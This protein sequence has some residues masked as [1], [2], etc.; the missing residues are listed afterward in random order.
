MSSDYNPDEVETWQR[1][2]AVAKMT[3][4]ANAKGKFFRDAAKRLARC[5]KISYQDALDVL[6][7]SAVNATAYVA[8]A[9][10]EEAKDGDS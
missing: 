6:H 5:T 9:K 2:H 7:A 4:P 1:A 8:K 3:F 10:I